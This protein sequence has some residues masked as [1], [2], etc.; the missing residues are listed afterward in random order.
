M[1]IKRNGMSSCNFECAAELLLFF[2]CFFGIIAFTLTRLILRYHQ[3]MTLGGSGGQR[4]ENKSPV[5]A[6]EGGIAPPQ[7]PPTFSLK[8]LSLTVFNGGNV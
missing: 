5:S 7:T 1:G 3:K 2:L 6:T 8:T 4:F